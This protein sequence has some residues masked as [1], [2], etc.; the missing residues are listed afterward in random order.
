MLKKRVMGIVLAAMLAV[1]GNA[2]ACWN[3]FTERDVTVGGIY[4]AAPFAEDFA[5][6]FDVNDTVFASGGLQMNTTVTTFATGDD[7]AL[8]SGGASGYADVDVYANNWDSGLSSGAYAEASFNGRTEGAG[9]AGAGFGGAASV[10]VDS[11]FSGMV[12]Q[13]QLTQEINY[14]NG[15]GITAYNTSVAFFSGTRSDSDADCARCGIAGAAEYDSIYTRGTEVTG[16]SFVTIDPYGN[17]RSYSGM[18]AST[19]EIGSTNARSWN[20]NSIVA[21][22]GSVGAMVTKPGN[23]YATGSASYSFT[24]E[25][26][27]AGMAQIQG[28]VQDYG[29]YSTAQSSGSSFAGAF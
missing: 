2:F 21:G 19:A 12:E 23:G 22:N 5:I 3:C 29:S 6:D 15:Q 26:A 18:T 24:G 14:Q 16:S 17:N 4:V 1:G 28:S 20:T 27:G 10:D 13:R 7:F 8:Q 9:L 11:S 25:N